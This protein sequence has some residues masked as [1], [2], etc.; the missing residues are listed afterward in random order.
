MRKFLIYLLGFFVL[1]QTSV[2]ACN[3]KIS[4]FGDPKEKVKLESI[5]PVLMPDRFGGESL[6]IPIQDLCKND[7]SLYG[8]VVI[9]LYI[10]N[11]LTRIQL[12]RPNMEDSKLMDYA[13]GRYGSFNLPEGVPKSRWRGN[14]FWESGN[15]I[16]EYIKTDIHDGYAEII[17][18]TSKLYSAGMAD[19]NEKVGE[20][21]DSQQ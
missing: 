14:Y 5:Q 8:T 12:Y 1:A 7:K 20:W 13:M 6:I 3:F 16:I 21:L 11:K 4:N 17:D 9:Y 2:I 15:D 10:E 18:I 19:Y